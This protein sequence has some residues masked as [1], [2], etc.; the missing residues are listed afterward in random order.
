MPLIGWA[1]Y[2]V[3]LL[4]ESLWHAILTSMNTERLQQQL[5]FIV[6]IDKLKSVLRRTYLVNDSRRENTAEHSWHLTVMAILLAEHSN[7]QID[8]LRILKMLI[9]HDIVEID[10]GD[11]FCYDEVGALTKEARENRAADRIFN[12][13]PI[14]QASELRGL[15]EEFEQRATSE[16][17]FAA[18][19]DRLIPLLHN[20]HTEGRSWRE[21]GITS[22]QVMQRNLHIGEGSSLLWEF[23]QN[24]INEAVERK[25]LPAT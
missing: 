7:E 10:A 19:L 5:Q 24:L 3:S 23:A 17:K 11:T 2:V 21:H 25:H 4:R 13:L 1:N 16:A 22:A 6:E 14:D 9:V 15:W 12:L 18:A 20:H 8:L